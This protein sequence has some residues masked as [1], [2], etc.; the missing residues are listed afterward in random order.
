M[1]QQNP[2]PCQAYVNSMA[3]IGRFIPSALQPLWK[4]P[5]GPQTVF[6]WAPLIKWGLVGA[7]LGDLKRPAHDLSMPQTFALAITGT[8]WS[9]YSVVIIPK[10]YGLLSVNAFVAVTNIYQFSRAYYAQVYTKS[11]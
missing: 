9:R 3:F 8:I 10:N 11:R 4:H 1:A 2:P 6:F 7:A 5:A